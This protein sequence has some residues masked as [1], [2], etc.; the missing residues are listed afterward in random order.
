MDSYTD[1]AGAKR[2]GAAGWCFHNGNNGHAK[3]GVPHRSFN[4]TPAAG[5]LWRQ[6][7]EVEREVVANWTTE[8][9]SSAA[10]TD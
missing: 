9:E 1:L 8:H 4:M 5:N 7:D 3:D 10:P 6:W 2:G